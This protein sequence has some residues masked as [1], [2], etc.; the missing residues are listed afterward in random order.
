MGEKGKSHVIKMNRKGPRFDEE[1][2]E[3]MPFSL[4][5]DPSNPVV[6]YLNE[7]FI[8]SLFEE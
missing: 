1:L 6:R 5:S 7:V 8:G 4:N 3:Q 2:Y